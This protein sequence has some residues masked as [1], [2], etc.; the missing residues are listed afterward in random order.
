MHSG[1][2]FGDDVTNEDNSLNSCRVSCWINGKITL[3]YLTLCNYT[4]TQI[5]TF[6][7]QEKQ[8]NAVDFSFCREG[9]EGLCNEGQCMHF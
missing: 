7:G 1:T 5:F 9:G 2:V 8:V 3:L 4:N 6:T